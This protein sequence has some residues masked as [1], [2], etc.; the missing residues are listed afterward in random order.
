MLISFIF[1]YPASA[2][3]PGRQGLWLCSRGSIRADNT[4]GWPIE[5]ADS[6]LSILEAWVY[7]KGS[8]LVTT[9]SDSRLVGR[10]IETSTSRLK[11]KPK[12]AHRCL[13][14]FAVCVRMVK[15]MIFSL[16]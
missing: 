5:Y 13:N 3:L 15:L 6:M 9:Y 7:P 8:L 4:L 16:F 2:S 11:I 14:H 1:Q 10:D 12:E